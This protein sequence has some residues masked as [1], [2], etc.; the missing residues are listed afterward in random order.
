VRGCERVRTSAHGRADAYRAPR[1]RVTAAKRASAD[2]LATT[3]SLATSRERNATMTIRVRQDAV[4]GSKTRSCPFLGLHTRGHKVNLDRD[5]TTGR[6]AAVRARRDRE[7]SVLTT[8]CSVVVTVK[9]GARAVDGSGTCR[10]K[11]RLEGRHTSD[12]VCAAARSSEP[13]MSHPLARRPTD[14]NNKAGLMAHLQF[15][16]AVLATRRT[17]CE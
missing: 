1:C 13:N 5:T 14:R 9:R 7:R 16:A 6:R 11:A 4:Q 8:Q 10:R 2:G 3:A 17:R 15:V 12:G